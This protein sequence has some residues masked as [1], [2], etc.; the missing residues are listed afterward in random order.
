MKKPS[1]SQARYLARVW[2]EDLRPPIRPGS[3]RTAD[4]CVAANWLTQT[5]ETY[6]YLNGWTA[7]RYVMTAYG[8]RALGD[9][10]IALSAVS[11]K[12]DGE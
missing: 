10:L 3:D 12:E 11:T 6:K 8:E 1:K 4:A 2:G 5:D 7:S 9:Y